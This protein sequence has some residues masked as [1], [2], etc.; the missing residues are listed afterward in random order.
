MA[1]AEL[2]PRP[3]TDPMTWV[4]Q[5]VAL[6]ALGV[7]RRALNRFVEQGAIR[8]RQFPGMRAQYCIEDVF[9]VRAGASA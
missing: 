2:V 8:R 7:D 6:N 4:S 3:G 1:M 5:R 9:A